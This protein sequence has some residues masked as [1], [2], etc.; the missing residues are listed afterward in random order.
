MGAI[1]ARPQ[2]RSIGTEK[3]VHTVAYKRLIALLVK[4]REEAGLTQRQLA[5][6]LDCHPSW[7]AKVEMGE[8]RLD[9]VEFI[10]VCRAVG[11]DPVPIVR[12]VASA[13]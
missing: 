1:L 11:Q 4:A 2:N 5:A 12:K 7:V 8:R 9:L 3:S 10:R 13:I 6:R